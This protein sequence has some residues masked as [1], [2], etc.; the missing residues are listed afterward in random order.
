MKVDLSY[1]PS[2]QENR[3]VNEVKFLEP[4]PICAC[5]VRA[6]GNVS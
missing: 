3:L 1:V 2:Q 4:I 6:N 5:M